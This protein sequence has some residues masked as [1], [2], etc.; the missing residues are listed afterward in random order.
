MVVEQDNVLA[1]RR[2]M[3]LSRG[4]GESSI[5]ARVLALF[6]NGQTPDCPAGSSA[7]LLSITVSSVTL[8]LSTYGENALTFD[9]KAPGKWGWTGAVTAT[10]APPITAGPLQ[11][12]G[13][14]VTLLPP[15][16]PGAAAKCPA[17]DGCGRIE[18]TGVPYRP[19]DRS[20]LLRG[21]LKARGKLV[22]DYGCVTAAGRRLHRYDTRVVEPVASNGGPGKVF[23]L[24]AGNGSTQ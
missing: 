8:E 3:P 2:G 4:P 20:T 16:V 1:T 22:R 15:T 23:T 12:D 11:L 9:Y 5:S 10:A 17:V 14:L 7:A 19:G 18:L 24:V 21:A 13:S 6:D